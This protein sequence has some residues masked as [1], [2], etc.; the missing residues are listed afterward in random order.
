MSTH[1]R[2]DPPTPA[3]IFDADLNAYDAALSEGWPIPRERATAKSHSPTVEPFS[4]FLRRAAR[5]PPIRE[6]ERFA[7]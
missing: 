4:A 5:L 7:A 6:Q 2:H 1:L 3:V